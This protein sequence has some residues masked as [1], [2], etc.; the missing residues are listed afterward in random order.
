[1]EFLFLFKLVL[2]Y[3][4]HGAYPVLRKLLEGNSAV[5]FGIIDIPADNTYI[6]F[7]TNIRFSGDRINFCIS[8]PSLAG[9]MTGDSCIIRMDILYRK[10]LAFGNTFVDRFSQL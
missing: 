4:T 8:L 1:M 2:T 3:T 5:F 7:H 9:E 6:A 10:S